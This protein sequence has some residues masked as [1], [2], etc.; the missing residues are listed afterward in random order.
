MFATVY[1][2]RI[3][4]GEESAFEQGWE[5]TSK[6]VRDIFGSLGSRL[7]RDGAGLYVFYAV[8]RN[9]DDLDRYRQNFRIDP[10]G[11]HLMQGAVAEEYPPWHLEILGNRLI[12]G[13]VPE[14]LFSEITG[15]S[16]LRV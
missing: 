12:E 10:V 15:S 8:W 4:D 1:R 7:H 5:R 6:V 14:G 13:V 11:F 16:Q 9:A 2:W 3:I